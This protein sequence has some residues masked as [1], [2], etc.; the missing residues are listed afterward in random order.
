[1]FLKTPQLRSQHFCKG[2]TAECCAG[3][4][5]PSFTTKPRDAKLYVMTR[6][7]ATAHSEVHRFFLSKSHFDHS[8]YKNYLCMKNG[9][10]EI[11]FFQPDYVNLVFVTSRQHAIWASLSKNLWPS[12]ATVTNYFKKIKPLQLTGSI[13]H[14]FNLKWIWA[15]YVNTATWIC[16]NLHSFKFYNSHNIQQTSYAYTYDKFSNWQIKWFVW[17][18]LSYLHHYLYI[19]LIMIQ[20]GHCTVQK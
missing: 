15:V 5:S 9:E 14:I 2:W 13:N 10:P 7:W 18:L 8:F 11:W 17:Q 6:H 16:Q 4:A 1:M 12:V 19:W 20:M 3:C